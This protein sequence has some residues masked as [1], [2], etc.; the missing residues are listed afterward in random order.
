MK[1]DIEG[2]EVEVLPDLALTGALQHV[3]AVMTEWHPGLA[4]SPERRY[5]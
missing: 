4:G 1:M 3:D 2:S 5:H